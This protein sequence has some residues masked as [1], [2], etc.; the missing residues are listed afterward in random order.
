MIDSFGLPRACH[1]HSDMFLSE[2]PALMKGELMMVIL[3]L[4][5]MLPVLECAT[6]SDFTPRYPINPLFSRT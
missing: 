4:A 2:I 5:V 6:S 3:H 1:C